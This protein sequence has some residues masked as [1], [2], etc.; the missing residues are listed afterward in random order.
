MCHASK[1]NTVSGG[2]SNGRE[3][4]VRW[5]SVRGGGWGQWGERT[6]DRSACEVWMDSNIVENLTLNVTYAILAQSHSII[7]R[8][9]VLRYRHDKDSNSWH[10]R[11]RF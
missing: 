6:L 9:R 11:E 3:G 4:G 7:E 5:G 1:S 2:G 10:R 8:W